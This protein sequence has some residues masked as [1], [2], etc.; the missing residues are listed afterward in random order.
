MLPVPLR[1]VELRSPKSKAAIPTVVHEA[2]VT[3]L[4]NLAARL[5]G[6]AARKRMGPIGAWPGQIPLLLWLLE[7][8]QLVQ[9]ELVQLTGME[10][11]TVAEH[12]ERMERD[13]LVTRRRGNEDRRQYSFSLTENGREAA[14]Q[15]LNQ[16][17]TGAQTFT[18]GIRQEDLRTFTDVLRQIIK[19]LDAFVREPSNASSS[20]KK[21]AGRKPTKFAA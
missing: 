19:R 10:Q 17:E 18:S 16:V 14:R 7:K 3:T 9:K 15:V 1:F 12:L 13:R 20:A 5:T 11:S 6:R 21:K 2:Q 4:I 8:K